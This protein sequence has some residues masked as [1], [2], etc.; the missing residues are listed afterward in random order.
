[1]VLLLYCGV[2]KAGIII[3]T[4]PPST[5]FPHLNNNNITTRIYFSTGLSS[6][7]QKKNMLINEVRDHE[8]KVK[9]DVPRQN[10]CSWRR[11]LAFICECLKNDLETWIRPVLNESPVN[12]DITIDNYRRSPSLYNTTSLKCASFQYS[13]WWWSPPALACTINRWRQSPSWFPNF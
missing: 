4:L 1:M 10:D 9:K 3:V 6:V 5:F 7:S 8:D 11:F 2:L 12:K 13:V